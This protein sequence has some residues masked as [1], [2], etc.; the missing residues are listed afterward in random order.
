[1]WSQVAEDTISFIKVI[2]TTVQAHYTPPITLSA[3]AQAVNDNI[4]GQASI[5]ILKN[6]I[7]EA[8]VAALPLRAAY[9]EQVVHLHRV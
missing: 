2:P 8:K 6:H 5:S 4:V 3:R 1:M 9:D 7:T